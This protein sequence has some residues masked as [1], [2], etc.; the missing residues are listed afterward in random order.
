MTAVQPHLCGEKSDSSLKVVSVNGSTP[1]VWGKEEY[2]YTSKD[3]LRFNPTCVGKRRLFNIAKNE[4]PVQP[5]LCG[6]KLRFR[7]FFCQFVGSTPPVWG[8]AER[9][10]L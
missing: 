5:H 9:V 3:T 1:P 6:E 4:F 8:K 10:R 2:K 7:A